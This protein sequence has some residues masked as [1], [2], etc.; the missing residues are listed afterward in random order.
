MGGRYREGLLIFN[1]Y[2]LN[3]EKYGLRLKYINALTLRKL[4]LPSIYICDCDS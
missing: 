4:F 2:T 1:E 3:L